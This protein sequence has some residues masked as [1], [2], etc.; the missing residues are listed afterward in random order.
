SNRWAASLKGDLAERDARIV[1]LQQEMDHEQQAAREMAEG[2]AAKVVELEA[3]IEAKKQGA[4][5]TETRLPAEV[6]HQA[7]ELAKAVDALHHTEQELDERSRW[8]LSLQEEAARLAQLLA[9]VR[10]SRWVRLGR[11]VGLGPE[12]PAG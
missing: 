6:R 11:K 1:E 5:D 2:Y 8:A 4:I 12:L 3:D 7:G 10:G 9:L